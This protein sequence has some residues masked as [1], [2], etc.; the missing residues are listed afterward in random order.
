MKNLIVILSILLFGLTSCEKTAEEI[1]TDIDQSTVNSYQFKS[2]A[3]YGDLPSV[4]DKITMQFHQEDLFGPG[5]H[6]TYVKEANVSYIK[7]LPNGYVM[8]ISTTGVF[9]TFYVQYNSVGL[10]VDQCSGNVTNFFSTD[11]TSGSGSCPSPIVGFEPDG[12]YNWKNNGGCSQEGIFDTNDPICAGMP[13]WDCPFTT[14]KLVLF[15]TANNIVLFLNW[16]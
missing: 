13:Y 6:L 8:D 1:T 5:G 14:P 2:T 3:S 15:H 4:G 16:E 11:Q 10:K 9:F 7:G 12:Q